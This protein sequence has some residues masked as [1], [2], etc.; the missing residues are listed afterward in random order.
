MVTR[1]RKGR[2]QTL[3]KRFAH[4]F[5]IFS[6]F[7]NTAFPHRYMRNLICLSWQHPFWGAGKLVDMANANILAALANRPPGAVF[8]VCKLDL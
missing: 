6:D 8:R 5:T 1:Q 7:F 4:I 2:C 3:N